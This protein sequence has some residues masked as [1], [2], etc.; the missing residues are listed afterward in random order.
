[1]K[2][3]HHVKHISQARLPSPIHGRGA[4][5]EGDS[6]PL[7]PPHCTSRL[8]R[9]LLGTLALVLLLLL[10]D[11]LWPPPLPEK[12][13]Y[14]RSLLDAKGEPLRTRPAKNGV[15]RYR[16]RASEV[17]P[18]YLEAL[19]AYEDRWFHWHPGINPFSLLRAL[20][21]WLLH[22]QIVSGGSTLTMQVARILEPHPRT[23]LGKTRQM[24]RALQL[25]RRFSKADILDLYLN[26][27]PFGANLAGVEAAARGWLGK[28]A[29]DLSH[30]EAALLTVLPQAPSR[31]RPDRWPKRAQA[32]RDKVL[33]R[34][35]QDGIWDKTSIQEAKAELV[36]AQTPRLPMRAPLLA[37][38]LWRKFPERQSI[39][40]LIDGQLQTQL[41]AMLQDYIQ[42]LPKPASAAAMVVRNSDG[43]VLASIGSADYANARRFGFLDMTRAIRSPGS[44]LKPFLYA[45]AID[46]GLIHSQS[47]L[48]DVPRHHSDYRPGNFD[49]G[50]TGPVTASE[51]LQRSLNLPAVQLLEHHGPARL[52]AQLQDAGL[53]IRIPGDGRPSL[54]IILGGLGV[55]LEQLL[56]LYTAF[57]RQGVAIRPRYLA[58]EPVRERRLF[59]Q[60]A[61]WIG[62]RMLADNPARAKVAGRLGQGQRELAWKTG[63]SYGYRDSWA[64]GTS[65]DYSIGVWLGRPDNTPLPGTHALA[66]AAPLLFRIAALLPPDRQSLPRP[67]SV[68]EA[69]ICHPLGT[70]KARTQPKDCHIQYKAWLLE[71]TA[72]PTL[73]EVGSAPVEPLVRLN[74]DAEGKRLLPGCEGDV[75]KTEEMALWPRVLEPW[76]PDNLKAEHLLPPLAP[77]CTGPASGQT[78]LR[79]LDIKHKGIYRRVSASN[80]SLRLELK[81]IG[82][83]GQRHWY[84]NGRHIAS[85]GPQESHFVELSRPGPV[86]I[87]VID[88]AGNLDQKSIHL[89]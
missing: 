8:C 17:S 23:L 68:S 75:I 39:Q 7:K 76:L 1:M 11:R 12:N 67:D 45:L 65:P 85:T 84:L 30:A 70:L 46:E 47:L 78:E 4:G 64:L 89:Q 69:L 43:A 16:V 29:K 31:L 19:L 18:L 35:E 38:R 66:N 63:T 52:A 86:Q 51:A 74:L 50:F 53:E 34:L 56:G 79:I 14:A 62:Y 37:E 87:M 13:L 5:G 54:S 71:G 82:G 41:E 15:L 44:S 42:P 9:L 60:G 83:Q 3:L 40:T 58:E 2:L 61:A 32:A 59:S 22:G 33:E 27:A 10:A 88:E 49:Q 72:P 25:E 81:A 28:S 20:G 73:N 48:L 26:L 80:P 57:A 55:R 36:Y 6:A 24:L 21:Q 77:G